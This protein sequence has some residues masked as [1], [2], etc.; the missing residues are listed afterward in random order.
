MFNL[1]FRLFLITNNHKTYYAAAVILCFTSAYHKLSIG[2]YTYVG[3][4]W[5]TKTLFGV[6]LLVLK[7]QSQEL[8]ICNVSIYQNIFSDMLKWYWKRPH[9]FSFIHRWLHLRLDHHT[10]SRTQDHLQKN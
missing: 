8:K 4:L 3:T 1:H 9:Q 6:C 7:R 5:R 10:Y 2:I